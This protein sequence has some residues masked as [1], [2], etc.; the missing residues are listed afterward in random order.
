MERPSIGSHNKQEVCVRWF[1]SSLCLLT[2]GCAEFGAPSGPVDGEYSQHS[3]AIRNGTREPQVLPLT[4][5][6]KLAI[7]WLHPPGSAGANFC[8][9]T[10][11]APRVVATARHCVEGGGRRGI[12][13]GV[14]LLP[15]APVRTFAVE[16]IH[17]ND[18]VDAAILILAEDATA[19]LPEIVP[20]RFNRDAPNQTMVGREVEAAGYGETYDANRSGRYFAVVQL[21]RVTDT[22]VIVDGRGRQGICFGDS[23]GPVMTLNEGG[24]PVVLGV[25]S[26]GDPSCWGVDHLTRL[27]QIAD[28]IDERTGLSPEAPEPCGD[29]DAEGQCAGEVFEWCQDD[30]LRRRNCAQAALECRAPGELDGGCFERDPCEGITSAGVCDGDTVV[31]CRFGGLV[32]EHCAESGQGCSNDQGGAFCAAIEGDPGN[33]P[34]DPTESLG[35]DGGGVEQGEVAGADAGLT[36]LEGAG[37]ERAVADEGCAALPAGEGVHPAFGVLLLGLLRRRRH[38]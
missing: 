32:R 26:W 31:R 6:Q 5:G 38:P 29:V 25:E 24:E 23:G 18:R 37:S 20:I 27:D 12:Q 34:A 33:D 19:A 7:G 15:S 28:W 36:A 8:T 30:R 17:T 13:F 11:V 14:G 10:L 22:E 3:Q 35:P 1:C 9:G 21:T 16:D 4:D 2:I